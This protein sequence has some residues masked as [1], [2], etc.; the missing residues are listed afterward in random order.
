M[1]EDFLTKVEDLE[2][3]QMFLKIGI[4]EAKTNKGET[5]VLCIAYMK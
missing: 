3:L 4:V 5:E 2:I 1:L